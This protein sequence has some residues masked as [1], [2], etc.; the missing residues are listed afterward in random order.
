M[1][2]GP[3]QPSELARSG[4]RCSA[5]PC[6]DWHSGDRRG[7]R[8]GSPKSGMGFW[9]GVSSGSTSVNTAAL[10]SA[11]HHRDLLKDTVH[12][13]PL[14]L[15]CHDVEKAVGCPAGGGV[16]ECNR[17]SRKSNYLTGLPEFLLDDLP[18][19][20]AG[21]VVR[22]WRDGMEAEESLA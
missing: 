13:C 16:F 20:I 1:A 21:P 14:W 17:A 3:Q 8:D 18:P 5:A 19:G 9:G 4:G 15:V 11:T 2:V 12:S 10:V 6:E 22:I 7:Q